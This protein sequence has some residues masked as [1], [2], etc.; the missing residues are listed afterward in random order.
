MKKMKTIHKIAIFVLTLMMILIPAIQVQA[1]EPLYVYLGEIEAVNNELIM[2][3]GT[4]LENSTEGISYK[5]TLG[6]EEL[7]ILSVSDYESEKMQTSYV[8]LVDVSG[9]IKK[10][11]MDDIK[12]ILRSMINGMDERDNA[13]IM[14]IGN[15]VYAETFTS[16]KET[17]LQ[18]VENIETLSEDTN[19]YYAINQAID[20]LSTSEQCLDRKCIVIL[21]DGQDDQISGITEKEVEEKINEVNIPICSVAVR[22]NDEKAVE[23]AKVMGSFSRMS[24]GG[25]HMIYGVE[26]IDAE[27]VA[28]NVFSVTENIAVLK[29]DIS[30]YEAN[31]T[32]NYLQVEAVVDGVGS[33]ADGYNVK[34]VFISEGVIEEEPESTIE[35]SEVVESTEEADAEV[36]NEQESNGLSAWIIVLIIAGIVSVIV[37]AVIL[38]VLSNK[39]KKAKAKALLEEKERA[40]KAAKDAENKANEEKIG[41][42]AMPLM[43]NESCRTEALPDMP[44]QESVA[45]PTLEVKLTRVGNIEKETLTLVIKGELTIGR[46][47]GQADVVFEQ[48]HQLSGKHCKLVYDGTRVML[49]DLGSLNG[50]LV[51]GVPISEPYQLSSDDKFYIGSMEWRINW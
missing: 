50:T 16:D 47:K 9:S 6:D 43:D 40:A 45:T 22:G 20:V 31:G 15:D 23:I 10:S 1:D 33:A 7:E 34:S 48:D 25:V 37:I 46:K 29:A 32:E 26:D 14:L 44:V 39:K 36:E 18:T 5:V 49:V 4:N 2:Q 35:E 27:A 51:N 38:I 3:V 24:P 19:L 12:D 8:F 42:T 17:L 21:S 13:S 28:Q 11:E 41:K 30:N